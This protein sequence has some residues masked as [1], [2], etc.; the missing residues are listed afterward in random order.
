MLRPHRLAREG[1]SHRRPPRAVATT[2]TRSFPRRLPSQSQRRSTR[3]PLAQHTGSSP[4]APHA[5]LTGGWPPLPFPESASKLSPPTFAFGPTSP[6][7]LPGSSAGVAAD[8]WSLVLGEELLRDTRTVTE[9]RAAVGTEAR[10]STQRDADSQSPHKEGGGDLRLTLDG[11]SNASDLR[12][13]PGLPNVST[14]GGQGTEGLL[15]WA[16]R[17]GHRREHRDNTDQLRRI[18][19][20]R[21]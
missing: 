8:D 12:R 9:G 16:W 2:N 4:T 5:K 17:R 11:R 20:A 21:R 1:C 19:V 15:V 10:A 6:P 18:Q 14:L 7:A 13:I 3:T